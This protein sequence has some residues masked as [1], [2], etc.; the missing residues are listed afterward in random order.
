MACRHAVPRLARQLLSPTSSAVLGTAERTAVRVA[1]RLVER[2]LA[3][4][5][6]GVLSGTMLPEHA[7]HVGSKRAVV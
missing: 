4:L 2:Q 6:T 3:S 7:G 1:D 5:P